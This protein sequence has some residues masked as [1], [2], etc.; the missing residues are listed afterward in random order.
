MHVTAP[1]AAA[2]A[3]VMCYNTNVAAALMYWLYW[4]FKENGRLATKKH[5]NQTAL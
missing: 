4:I 5:C 3:A 1:A 2:A